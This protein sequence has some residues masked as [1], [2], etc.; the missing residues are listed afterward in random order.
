MTAPSLSRLSLST[1]AFRAASSGSS[2]LPT[3]D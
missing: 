2:L 1:S 3:K